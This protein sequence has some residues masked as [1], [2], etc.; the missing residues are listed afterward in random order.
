MPAAALLSVHHVLLWGRL[1]SNFSKVGTLAFRNPTYSCGKC[2][3]NDKAVNPTSRWAGVCNP[4]LNVL[5]TIA[6]TSSGMSKRGVDEVNQRSPYRRLWIHQYNGKI[7]RER[8]RG[9]RTAGDILVEWLQN[10]KTFIN[11]L[12]INQWR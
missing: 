2:W 1:R 9:S 6:I 12:T 3:V 10:Y 8:E 7:I 11:Q 4:G 5:I